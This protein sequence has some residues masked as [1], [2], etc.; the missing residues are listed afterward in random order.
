MSFTVYP[1][2]DIRNGQVVRLLQGDYARETR[3][4][5]DPLARAQQFAAVGAASMHLVDLDAAKAG[6]YTLTP[7]IG[8]IAAATGLRVQTGGGVRSR[9][10]VAR[11]LDAGAARVV[12]GSLAVR[13][14]E[15]VIAWI[16]E[17]GAERITVALDTRRD[18]FGLWRLP[19]HGWTETADTT[20]DE[21]AVR[22]ARAGLRHLL[23]TDIARDGMLIG[24]DMELYAH[25]RGLAPELQVQVS[26]GAR[27]VADVLAAKAAGCAGI[28]LGKALLEGHLQLQEALAC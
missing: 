23:C 17:F 2:L 25:L 18:Q 14:S 13:E 16:D 1:A 11:I 5:D 19:V 4:G 26:G 20:L 6:G 24:P 22:Y 10:D 27:D 12:I 21:L 28:V 15:A 9:D 8:Q 3:Y 7:L